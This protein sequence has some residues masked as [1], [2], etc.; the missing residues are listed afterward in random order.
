[1]K[2]TAK[3]WSHYNRLIQLKIELKI[4]LLDYMLICK[5]VYLLIIFELNT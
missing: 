5:W 2:K 1:M 4:P 3:T